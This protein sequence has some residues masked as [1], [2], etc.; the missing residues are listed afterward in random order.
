M[1]P[2]GSV[3]RD[4]FLGVGVVQDQAARCGRRT[5]GDHQRQ[6]SCLL[7]KTIS[8]CYVVRNLILVVVPVD[9]AR[10]F[11]EGTSPA[12][13]K[14]MATCCQPNRALLRVSTEGCSAGEEAPNK[15]S[16]AAS[17]ANRARETIKRKSESVYST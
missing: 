1:P 12:V 6:G 10:Q 7:T 8:I 9:E 11:W 17:S 14:K 4:S 16:H 2:S 15:V 13:R 5:G 3:Q